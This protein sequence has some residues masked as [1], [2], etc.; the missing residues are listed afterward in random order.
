MAIVATAQNGSLKVTEPEFDLSQPVSSVKYQN[1]A[2]AI[3]AKLP[4]NQRYM[5][6][7][8]GDEYS[9]KGVGFTQ[10]EGK[11]TLLTPVNKIIA[12]NFNGGKVVGMRVAL[13]ADGIGAITAKLYTYNIS[14]GDIEYNVVA[15]KEI[16]STKKGWNDCT[17]S[18]PYALD[19]SKV[20]GVMLGFTYTTE[21]RVFS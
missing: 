6:N 1:N 5:G 9:E 18:T 11:I 14:G 17:F 19:L 8:S 2:K 20:E 16:T 15:E 4:A 21:E 10:N 7:Y 13:P 12:E 3:R